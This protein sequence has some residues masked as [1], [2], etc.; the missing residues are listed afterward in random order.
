MTFKTP[1]ERLA[2]QQIVHE[3]RP[4]AFEEY[5]P[6]WPVLFA[7]HA[8][9]IQDVLSAE[10]LVVEHVGSTSVPGMSAKPQID[11]LVIVKNL[12]T[13]PQYYE[14]MKQKG[15]TARGDYTNEGEEYFTKDGLDGT[16][17]VSVHVLPDGHPWADELIAFRDYLRS[18]PNEMEY[19][20]SAK[21]E[22]NRMYPDDYTNYY[23]HKAPILKEVKKRALAWK[24]E[25]S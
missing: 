25:K 9:V 11:V 4:Y 21:R 18:H 10:A 22:G 23:I 14:Q 1:E 20:R 5:D 15:F 17:Q 13:I 8:D 16:R 24:L 3:N 6:K 12:D 7:E 19:Y 2:R